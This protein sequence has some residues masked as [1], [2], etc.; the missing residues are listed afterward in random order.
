MPSPH[1]NIEDEDRRYWE[2]YNGPA[3]F[4][5]AGRFDDPRDGKGT[6]IGPG[7]YGCPELP[8]REPGG[9][10]A[11]NDETL[12]MLP[13]ARG[14]SLTLVGGAN[15]QCEGREGAALH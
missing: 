9:H 13:L 8:H 11:G 5:K 7:Q 3:T 1:F 12:P 2:S 15:V 4:K 10:P 6:A 14:S